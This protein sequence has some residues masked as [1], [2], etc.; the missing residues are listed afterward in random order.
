M[1]TALEFYR[2]V[3]RSTHRLIHTI[4]FWLTGLPLAPSHTHGI[5]SC[6]AVV[7]AAHALWGAD[8]DYCVMDGYFNRIFNHSWLFNKDLNFIL[9]VY[10]VASLATPLLIDA[11]TPAWSNLYTQSSVPGNNYLS[12]WVEETH[13]LL[14]TF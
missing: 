10:P 13:E 14:S 12:D 2:K 7:R 4:E 5:W 6:H 8:Q 1:K 3:P 11:A 9:D